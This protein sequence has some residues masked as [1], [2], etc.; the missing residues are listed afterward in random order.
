MVTL[1]SGYPAFA[2]VFVAAGVERFATA[3]AAEVATRSQVPGA[4]TV[5]PG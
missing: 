4:A 2:I 1:L 3:R 5:V